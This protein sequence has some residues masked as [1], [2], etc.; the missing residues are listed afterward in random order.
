MPAVP[1]GQPVWI[2]AEPSTET[3]NDTDRRK[4]FAAKLWSEQKS[5][6]TQSVVK[7]QAKAVWMS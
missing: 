6:V 1:A 5:A 3:L 7:Q 4:V 2:C